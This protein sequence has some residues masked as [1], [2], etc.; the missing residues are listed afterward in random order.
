MTRNILI[1]IALF[2]GIFV[3]EYF[4]SLAPQASAPRAQTGSTQTGSHIV[5]TGGVS[6]ISDTVR[7]KV[8]QILKDADVQRTLTRIDHT[9]PKYHQDN[10][11]FTNREHILQVQTDRSY[12]REWTV[13][14]PESRDRGP[15]RI[16]VGKR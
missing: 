8:T 11:I 3:L 13:E 9:D 15:R 4:S 2:L 12:Y 5:E 1:I 7:A 14:T 6:Q 10:A 16:I